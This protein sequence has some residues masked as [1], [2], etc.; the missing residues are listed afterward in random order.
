MIR[1]KRIIVEVEDHEDLIFEPGKKDAVSITTSMGIKEVSNSTG[2]VIKE[3]NGL[4]VTNILIASESMINIVKE[5]TNK[6]IEKLI[7]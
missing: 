3:H 2:I 1:V 5:D 6:I 7:N 4:K